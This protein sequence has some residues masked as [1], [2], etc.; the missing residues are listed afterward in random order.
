MSAP[1]VTFPSCL[2]QTKSNDAKRDFL[3]TIARNRQSSQNA[4]AFLG[5]VMTF[6][7]IQ[8]IDESRALKSSIEKISPASVEGATVVH[9]KQILKSVFKLVGR[10]CDAFLED[11]I[12]TM[13]RYLDFSLCDKQHTMCEEM[14]SIAGEIRTS[15]SELQA[16]ERS[17]SDAMT[18]LVEYA[19]NPTK[20][21]VF[22]TTVEA[23]DEA[24]T[25]AQEDQKTLL[26]QGITIA[27]N[28]SSLYENEELS[29]PA[30]Y[31]MSLYTLFID[32]INP[33]LYPFKYSRPQLDVM[34]S[35][36]GPKMKTFANMLLSN[37][38]GLSF[39]TH[40]QSWYMHFLAFHAVDLQIEFLRKFDRPLACFAM[41]QCESSNKVKKGAM[42]SLYSFT[43]RPIG[44]SKCPA[45]VWRNKNGFFIARRR[46]TQLYHCGD[47]SHTAGSKQCPANII[48]SGMG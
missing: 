37:N 28:V 11:T 30:K 14:M 25:A 41:Q 17:L 4:S 2:L 6:Q 3:V 45:P 18:S 24:V 21:D 40:P 43:N 27:K 20:Q 16:N 7:E 9:A 23:L 36:V 39:N 13:I 8:T 44:N 35:Q 32:I 26:H 10:D 48:L 1:P 5:G 15:Q 33:F 31:C 34:L 42:G 46:V 38:L 12:P 47:Y 29:P 19:K 22:Q